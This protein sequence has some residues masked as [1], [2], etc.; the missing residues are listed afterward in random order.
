MPK[1]IL[2]PRGQHLSNMARKRR[3]GLAETRYTHLLS[4]DR[5]AAAERVAFINGTPVV[6]EIVYAPA[7]WT[8]AAANGG[9]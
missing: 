7:G 8:P 3:C 9:Q 2:T 6:S 5:R 4:T 1:R